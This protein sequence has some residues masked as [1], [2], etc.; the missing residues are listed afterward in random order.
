MRIPGTEH[1]SFHRS[2]ERASTARCELP[3]PGPAA[4]SKAEIEATVSARFRLP[5]AC[6]DERADPDPRPKIAGIFIRKC[7]SPAS[8]NHKNFGSSGPTTGGKIRPDVI[9]KADQRLQ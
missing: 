6:S 8:R 1:R 7:G 3:A 2:A 5:T 4:R 9:R